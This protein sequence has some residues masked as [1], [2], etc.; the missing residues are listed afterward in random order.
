MAT[1]APEYAEVYGVPFSFLP[2]SG[3]PGLIVQKE[4]HRVRALSERSDLEV[5]FPRLLGYR[6]DLPTASLTACR[7]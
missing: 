1:S 3:Q 6:Y 5:T 4:I 2:T 7:L